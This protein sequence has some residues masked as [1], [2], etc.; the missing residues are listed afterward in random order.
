MAYAVLLILNTSILL[1]P[2]PGVATRTTHQ[3]R[4]NVTNKIADNQTVTFLSYLG[5]TED[6]TITKMA[7]APDDSVYII[8]T[9]TSYEFPQL[10]GSVRRFGDVQST[11]YR[12]TYTDC[13][14]A[15]ITSMGQL[16]FFDQFGGSLYDE[17]HDL[18]VTNTGDVIVVGNTMSFNFP[19]T[20]DALQI[21]RGGLLWDGFIT[22][23]TP[24]GDLVYSTFLGGYKKDVITGI[25]LWQ[26]EVIITGWTNSP[27][28]PTKDTTHNKYLGKRDI[29]L[30]HLTPDCKNITFSMFLGSAGDEYPS[31]SGDCLEID[32]EGNAVIIGT[33]TN[34][35]TIFTKETT[36]ANSSFIVTLNRTGSVLQSTVVD[37]GNDE[38]GQCIQ[39]SNGA[40]T[41]IVIHAIDRTMFG[42]GVRYESLILEMDYQT[43]EVLQQEILSTEESILATDIAIDTDGS[44]LIA[45]WTDSWLQS[46]APLQTRLGGIDFYVMRLNETL[47]PSFATYFGGSDAEI[48]PRIIL[49][50]HG[51]IIICGMTNSIDIRTK[52]AFQRSKADGDYDFDGVIVCIDLALLNQTQTQID[53]SFLQ[54]LALATVFSIG[55][56]LLVFP[57]FK[58]ETK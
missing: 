58:K 19:H 12:S 41:A 52:N 36:I 20:S 34:E 48:S 47:N 55:V 46:I 35:S 9:T 33:M 28:F 44:P 54:M 57:Y 32:D 29:F 30:T 18:V 11:K 22:R 43:G 26:Q 23:F 40:L 50:S 15:R 3:V 24:N 42:E 17:P 51:R 21:D 4:S 39:L 16:V 37:L 8:G 31:L 49:D 27:N 7:I 13:F 1:T 5:G 6:E 10:E 25:E 53:Y 14:L 45:L 2:L 38:Y 56:I